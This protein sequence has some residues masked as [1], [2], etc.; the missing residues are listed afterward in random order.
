MTTE[1]R[2]QLNLRLSA[3]MNISVSVTT[4]VHDEDEALETGERNARIINA[5]IAGYVRA[6][7]EEATG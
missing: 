5:Y 6:N 3:E 4:F 1:L 7:E 2:S